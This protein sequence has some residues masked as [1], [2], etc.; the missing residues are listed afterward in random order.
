MGKLIVLVMLTSAMSAWAAQPGWA[1]GA[2]EPAAT[3]PPAIGPS[4]PTTS[5]TVGEERKEEQKK[6]RTAQRVADVER[7]GALVAPWRL[8]I[9]PFFEYDNLSSQNVAISGFTVFEAILIGRVSLNR[10]RRDIFTTGTAVRFGM[11]NSEVY[12]RVPYIFRTD[13]L[14]FAGTG[15]QSNVVQKQNNS[16]SSIG[17]LELIYYYHLLR[18]GRWQYWVPDTIIRLGGRF[19]TGRDP[20]SLRREQVAGLG[21]IPVQFPTGTGHFGI[22]LGAN[23]VKSVDPVL[24]FLSLTY[25]HN[26]GRQVGLRNDVDFGF[27]DPGDAFEYNAGLIIALQEKISLNLF[28]RQLIVGNTKQNGTVLSES[29]INAISFNIGATYVGGPR[30]AVDCVVGIGLSP[31]AP[32]YSVLLRFPTTFQFRKKKG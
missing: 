26:F 3:Q 7:G 27:I 11:K 17:D 14:T 8:V 1:Q 12:F 9:E 24:V 20:Y 2:T 31:D 29:N 18:E 13:S 32:G 16:D 25:Y 30:W 22:N 28:A 10:V 6:A 15:T 5:E 23:F 19:P 21:L 4:T